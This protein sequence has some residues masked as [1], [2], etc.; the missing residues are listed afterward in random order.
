[1]TSCCR[2][3]D[4]CR[5]H[6]NG[7][8]SAGQYVLL[9]CGL[10]V[11]AGLATMLWMARRGH[12]SP[13]WLISAVVLGPV[14]AAMAPDRVERIPQVLSSQ[15]H[16]DAVDGA[17]VLVGVDGSPESEAALSAALD[18]VQDG[19]RSLLLA[20]VVDYDAAAA[21]E[22]GRHGVATDRLEAARALAAGH[23]VVCEVLSGPPAQALIHRAGQDDVDVLI[24]GRR[25]RGLSVRLLGSVAEEVVRKAPVPVLVAGPTEPRGRRADAHV[26]VTDPGGTSPR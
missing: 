26:Q 10:W 23:D 22:H 9:V 11:G 21:D 17:R 24:V 13:W 16:G 7:C 14:L 4:A 20:T 25:G 6:D 19:R 5:L 8:M 2:L 15:R 1:M 18:L 12:R 3:A